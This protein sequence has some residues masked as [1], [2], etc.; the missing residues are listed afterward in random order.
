LGRPG[1]ERLTAPWRISSGSAAFVAL[2]GRQHERHG[3]TAAI[4]ADV[5]LA[6]EAAAVAAQRLMMLPL[7]APAA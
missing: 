5:Q 1:P 4:A 6:A 2:A 3:P 7:L